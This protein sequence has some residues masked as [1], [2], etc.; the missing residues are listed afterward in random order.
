MAEIKLFRGTYR[1]EVINKMIF[2]E[3]FKAEHILIELLV[4]PIVKIENP[5]KFRCLLCNKA[6]SEY[7]QI[8]YHIAVIHKKEVD[9]NLEAINKELVYGELR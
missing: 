1:S 4:K 3:K 7:R 6:F 5:L 2:G 8:F 9:S